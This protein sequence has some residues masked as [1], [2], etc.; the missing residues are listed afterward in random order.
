MFIKN[1]IVKKVTNS[2]SGLTV[3]ILNNKT[4]LV[5]KKIHIKNRWL[6]IIF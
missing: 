2:L 4:K 1:Q 6:Q 5:L 3:D